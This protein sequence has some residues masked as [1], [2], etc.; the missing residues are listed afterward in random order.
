MFDPVYART[1]R[2]GFSILHQTSVSA[3][4][5]ISARITP[6]SCQW[7]PGAAG[8]TVALNACVTI[9]NASSSPDVVLGRETDQ[10]EL[11][12][13]PGVMALTALCAGTAV[14]V[15]GWIIG[16]LTEPVPGMPAGV[17][18]VSWIA[19]ALIALAALPSIV[20]CQ[21]AST[22]Q[23]VRGCHVRE[24]VFGQRQRQ[25][26]D[27]LESPLDLFPA[28]TSTGSEEGPRSQQGPTLARVAGL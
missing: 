27:G 5:R 23:S 18:A 26:D 8:T 17:P 22:W 25:R 24:S 15:F 7:R 10:Y 19:P 14:F 9:S 6:W 12:P 21:R 13:F 20:I 16:S 3:C 4:P 2:D 28:E 11:G 1:L